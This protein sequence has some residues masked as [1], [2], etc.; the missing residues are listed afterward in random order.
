MSKAQ[1]RKLTDK[2]V[3]KLF[4]DELETFI[5]LW[6]R[7]A[8]EKTFDEF[9]LESPEDGVRLRGVKNRL[10]YSFRSVIS[11]Q[12]E[13]WRLAETEKTF[14]VFLLELKARLNRNSKKEV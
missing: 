8:P 14:D 9:L 7:E 4:V 2:V 5:S 12:V 1:I 6:Q 11:V 3:L 13:L 10:F